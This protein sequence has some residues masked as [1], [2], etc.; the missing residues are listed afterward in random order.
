MAPDGHAPEALTSGFV[1]LKLAVVTAVAYALTKCWQEKA[2]M[3][4]DPLHRPT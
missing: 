3:P 2:A 4:A 1:D